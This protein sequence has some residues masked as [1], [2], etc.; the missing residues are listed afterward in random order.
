MR[1]RDLKITGIWTRKV[2]WIKEEFLENLIFNQ[3]SSQ[4]QYK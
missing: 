4:V 3:D 1:D 2:I